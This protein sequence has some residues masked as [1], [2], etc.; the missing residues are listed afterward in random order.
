MEYRSVKGFTGW[1]QTGFFLAFVGLGFVIAAGISIGFMM[2]LLG[3]NFSKLS[4]DAL[5]SALFKPEH[6]AGLKWMQILSSFAMLALPAMLWWRVVWGRK[7][8]WLGFNRHI[9]PMQ[10]LLGFLLMMAAGVVASS[11]HDLSRTIIAD[12]PDLY[13][14]AQRMEL[15]YAKQALALSV[16]NGWPDYFLA[17]LILAFLPAVFEELLFR[18]VLQNYLTRWWRSPW[19]AI[20]ITSI[21]FSAIHAS[22]F[23]F[24][25]R[26]IL[27][28]VLGL[29][30]HYSRNIWPGIVAHFINNALVVSALFFSDKKPT[31]A[32][33]MESEMKVN[34][35]FGAIAVLAVAGLAVFLKKYAARNRQRIIADE[36]IEYAKADP[37]GQIAHQS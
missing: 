31:V 15:E 1:A 30:F 5:M 14:R 3:D 12:Y 10:L 13:A 29:M 21:I 20:I 24:I 26:V 18:G 23:L 37:F 7:I 17:L 34:P 6:A 4:E 9:S 25:S 22:I 33:M 2:S 16:L 28:V 32:D 8:M 35:V 36:Q 11:A 19:T 27:G